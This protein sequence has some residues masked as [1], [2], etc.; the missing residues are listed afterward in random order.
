MDPSGPSQPPLNTAYEHPGNPASQSEGEKQ[1]S[2]SASIQRS[3][4]TIDKRERGDAPVPSSHGEGP[5]PSSLG[6]GAR[7]SSGDAGESKGEPVSSLTGEQMS[8]PGEGDIASAQDNKHGF[9]E[10]ADLAS[11]LDRKKEE[12][13]Q[14]LDDRYNGGSSGKGGPGGVDVESAIG[15]GGKGVVGA[16]RGSGARGNNEGEEGGGRGLENLGDV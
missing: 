7:D 15:G 9:G 16:G 10:Q 14:R 4:P 8:A 3:D 13:Q 2:T 12:Q 6:Y 5:T 11:G 1:S